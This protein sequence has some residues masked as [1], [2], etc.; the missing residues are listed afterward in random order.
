[1]SDT[2]GTWR[3]PEDDLRRVTESE[4]RFQSAIAGLSDSDVKRPSRLPG[5]T[6][7]HVLTHVARNADSHRVRAEAAKRGEVVDQYPGGYAGRSAA[8][9]AGAFRAA[10]ELISDVRASA[11]AMESAWRTVPGPAWVN[12][13]RDV[14]GQMRPLHDLPAR[15]MQEL[16]VHLV[17][18][19]IGVT[20]QD[21]TSEFVDVWL[22]RMRQSLVERLPEGTRPPAPGVID[23]RDELAWLYGR[24]RR[25]DL[26]EL[27]PW[28]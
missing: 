8:I 2:S 7:A 10:S 23:E 3:I 15:R 26:P 1:M 11:E 16:E 20:H 25:A 4:A 9:D 18:L 12:G 28:G 17:D 6:V 21:W 5:W 27:G 19:D 24:L 13:T 14:S 22:P